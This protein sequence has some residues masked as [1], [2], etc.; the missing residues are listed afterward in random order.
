ML[1]LI[2][3]SSRLTA[4]HLIRPGRAVFLP[5]SAAVSSPSSSRLL[6]STPVW[7]APSALTPGSGKGGKADKEKAA[8]EKAVAAK[9]RDKERAAREKARAKELKD[10]E[11]ERASKIKA[12]EKAIREKEKDKE[13]KD[14]AK[15]KAGKYSPDTP[16]AGMMARVRL[17]ALLTP[18]GDST[19]G[20]QS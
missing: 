11:K 18:V 14:K 4:R 7:Q 2:L 12:K 9:Q 1:N 13:Q 20:R 5:A 6:S 10:K 8:K 15:I 16:E 19:C 3:T 17:S